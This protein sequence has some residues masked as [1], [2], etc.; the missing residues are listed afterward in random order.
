MSAADWASTRGER[1]K[2]NGAVKRRELARGRGVGEGGV[3]SPNRLALL[4]KGPRWMR[5]AGRDSEYDR[6]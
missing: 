2:G 6:R 3:V 5:G 4:T 1:V